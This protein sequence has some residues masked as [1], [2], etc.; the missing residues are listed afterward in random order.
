VEVGEAWTRT[1]GG[2]GGVGIVVVGETV[3]VT[4]GRAWGRL[5]SER[6]NAQT[7]P[8]PATR[9]TAVVAPMIR[10]RVHVRR[11]RA[12]LLLGL[13]VSAFPALSGHTD[14]HDSGLRCRPA[15]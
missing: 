2:G 13:V 7:A 11:I 4:I 3:V 14:R 5:E 15:R 6:V 1:G 8:L 10:V 12:F 9:S